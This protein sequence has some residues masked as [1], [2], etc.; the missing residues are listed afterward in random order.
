[1]DQAKTKEALVLHYYVWE[2]NLTIPNISKLTG[3]NESRVST[4]LN[5]Y[6]KSKKINP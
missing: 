1:M 3:V 2:L 4:I 6:L 5:K